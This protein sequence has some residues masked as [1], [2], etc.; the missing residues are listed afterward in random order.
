MPS[1]GEMQQLREEHPGLQLWSAIPPD[2]SNPP[3]LGEVV[4]V[5][6]DDVVKALAKVR[7]D[8]REPVEERVGALFIHLRAST[9]V[10]NRRVWDS[11]V[12]AV[13]GES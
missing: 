10:N 8:E 2:L 6:F 12:R 3:V 11:I 13:R 7:A 9:S 4:V 5:E 1:Q